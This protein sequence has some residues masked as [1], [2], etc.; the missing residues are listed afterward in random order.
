VTWSYAYSDY[1]WPSCATVILVASLGWCGW[2]W[3]KVTGTG[4]MLETAGVEP[5]AKIFGLRFL[6]LWQSPV[7]TNT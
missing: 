4:S 5:G 6:I 1:L 2:R 3:R 7:V